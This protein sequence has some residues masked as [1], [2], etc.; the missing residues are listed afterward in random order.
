[1]SEGLGS[2]VE[3][4]SSVQSPKRI[5]EIWEW[6]PETDERYKCPIFRKYESC[7]CALDTPC[8]F[9]RR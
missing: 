3:S 5:Y 6:M 8:P 7:E 4:I 1:M 2:V 9:K